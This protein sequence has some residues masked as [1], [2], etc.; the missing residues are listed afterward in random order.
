M[1]TTYCHCGHELTTHQQIATGPTPLFHTGP[2][3][4]SGCTCKRFRIDRT[5]TRYQ[6]E[7]E[8]VAPLLANKRTP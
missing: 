2:C 1:I 3:T 7:Y 4:A 6:T 5:L 8:R